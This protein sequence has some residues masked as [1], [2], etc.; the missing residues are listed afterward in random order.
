[1]ITRALGIDVDVEVDLIPLPLAVG[2]RVLLCSDGLNAM[3]RDDDV[4]DVLR[5]V[6]DRTSA[7]QALVDAANGAGGVDNITV[8]LIDVVDDDTADDPEPEPEPDEAPTATDP[9]ADTLDLGQAPVVDPLADLDID[10]DEPLVPPEPK[11]H[12]WQ[13]RKQT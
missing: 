3:L 11:R 9:D 10:L 12:W 2:D 7:A 1:M 13:R 6:A 4:A 8:L 5:S